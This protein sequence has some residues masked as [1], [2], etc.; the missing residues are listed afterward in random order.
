MG[1]IISKRIVGKHKNNKFIFYLKGY[2][3]AVLR[4]RYYPS[5][6]N[7]KT[8]KFI[9]LQDEYVT[10]RVNYYNKLRSSFKNTNA[11][12][13]KDFKISKEYK[14]YYLDFFKFIRFF[15]KD[16]K[17]SYLFGDVT[18][19]PDEPTIVKSRPINGENK[20]SILL[21]L[22]KVR[23]F[24]FVSDSYK[25]EN[26]LNKLV[27]RGKVFN[28]M[29]QRELFMRAHFNNDLCDVGAVNNR[30]NNK[31]WIKPRMTID[32]QLQYKFILSIEGN[33][34]A[35][36]L[37][38]IMSSNSVAVMPKPTYETWFMEGTLVPDFHYICINSDYSDLHEKLTYY[39]NHP[40]KTEEIIKNANAYVNQFKNKKREELI[41]LLVLDR[42]FKFSI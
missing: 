28:H 3:Y 24:I 29:P 2:Y 21:N 42:Y 9:S 4:S 18:H 35:T 37:K 31:D 20:N 13:L 32:E 41:S 12:C 15:S 36:N 25:F 10:Y 6:F 19:V 30:P 17:L 27:W 11:I 14:T 7:K 34:V 39:I 26:K 16:K 33:D 1:K 23:H 22:N 5:L 40:E 38:W 8:K